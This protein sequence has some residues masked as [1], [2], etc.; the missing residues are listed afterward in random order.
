MASKL[1]PEH[2]EELDALKETNEALN[3]PSFIAR[4]HWHESDYRLLVRRGLVQWGDPPSGFDKRRFAGTLIT[5][6]GL[7]A[8]RS[9]GETNG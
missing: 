2:L 3:G 9:M 6:A 4:H 5:P 7:S 8:L 1:T